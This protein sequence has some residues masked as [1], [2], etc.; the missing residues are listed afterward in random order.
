MPRLKLNGEQDKR[1]ESSYKNVAKAR[2]KL[3]Q[4]LQ[5][6]KAL[7][8]SSSDEELVINYRPKVKAKARAKHAKPEPPSDSESESESEHA[9]SEPI[10]PIPAPAPAPKPS[11][12][13]G[14][15]IDDLRAQLLEL[16][17]QFGDAQTRP[18]PPA[19]TPKERDP[20]IHGLRQQMIASAL[21]F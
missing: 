7:R 21:R 4:Y 8:D 5:K 19:P 17:G 11:R 16:R 1:G 2:V 12:C 9:E 15:E 13:H 6:G 20:V 3:A 14:T 18:Q 10:P